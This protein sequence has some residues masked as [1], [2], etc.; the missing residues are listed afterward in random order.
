VEVG[1]SKRKFWMN[2]FQG[3]RIPLPSKKD[4]KW[5]IEF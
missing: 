5:G 4:E 3:E 2:G 1:D